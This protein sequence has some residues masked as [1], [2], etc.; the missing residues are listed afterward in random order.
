MSFIVTWFSAA[1]LCAFVRL[2]REAGRRKWSAELF[3]PALAL[4][5]VV[6]LA[7]EKWLLASAA[8]RTLRMALVQPAIPQW[9]SWDQSYEKKAARFASLLALSEAAVT[10]NP[11]V[12]VWPEAALPDLLRWS[13]NQYNGLTVLRV[14]GFARRH[15]V[16]M[17]IG[18]DDAELDPERAMKCRSTTAAFS[19]IP[20]AILSP[21]I[22]RGG[23]SCSANTCPSA[24]GFRF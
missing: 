22:A 7:F 14:T 16:W 8:S 20:P 15:K 21:A 6:A 11:T 4:A 12:V 1:L 2:S 5:V 10:N 3:V 13:T 17:V 9:R 19:S 18:A 24:N 23:W